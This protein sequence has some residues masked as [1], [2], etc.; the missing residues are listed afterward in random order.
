M[1]KW[2]FCGVFV[3]LAAQVQAGVVPGTGCA[4]AGR[5]GTGSVCN[6]ATNSCA[7][8]RPSP[9]AYGYVDTR[10]PVYTQNYTPMVPMAQTAP[11]GYGYSGAPGRKKYADRNWQPYVAGRLM[12]SKALADFSHLQEVPTEGA[13]FKSDIDDAVYGGALAFGVHVDNFRVELE[14]SMNSDA[15]ADYPRVPMTTGSIQDKMSHKVQTMAL[16]LNGYYDFK[17]G[18]ALTPFITGGLGV[19]RIKSKLNVI[20]PAATPS[21]LLVDF[22]SYSSNKTNFI[23]QLGAGVSYALDDKI[24]LDVGYRYT[25]YGKMPVLEWEGVA[26]GGPSY[27]KL[28][29]KKLHTHTFSLGLRFDL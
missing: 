10:S 9:Y 19:G 12:L 22:D 1:K 15:E 27:E 8:R 16:L 26:G 14:G 25:H 23:W 21:S 20:D 2:L 3:M 11:M 18:T 29:L 5:C 7:A 6:C 28:D 17:N 24:D 13:K 4:C